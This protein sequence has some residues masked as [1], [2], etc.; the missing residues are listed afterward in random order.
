M[1][2]V[3][4]QDNIE[5]RL[6]A[7]VGDLLAAM[8]SVHDLLRQLLELADT[9]LSAMRRADVEALRQCAT[10]ESSVLQELIER[11]KQRDA[12]LARLAQS[13]HWPDRGGGRLSGIAERLSEPFRSR[14]L[15]KTESLHQIASALRQK[16]RLAASVARNLHSHIRAV[17]DDVARVNQESVMYGP[18]GKHEHRNAQAWVDAVG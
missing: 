16:N 13:L 5:A 4:A 8:S 9:K 3:T 18:S 12:V 11:E 14:L 1:Q 2:I 10:D 7:H 15:A 6:E 17:F